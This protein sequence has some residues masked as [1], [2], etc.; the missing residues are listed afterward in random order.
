[1]SIHPCQNHYSWISQQ[2]F[3]I[4]AWKLNHLLIVIVTS[5]RLN[6]A[7]WIASEA[8]QY[9]FQWL[10]VECA[11]A[12]AA[13]S[14]VTENMIVLT[15]LLL[16]DRHHHHHVSS[17]CSYHNNDGHAICKV[18][19]ERSNIMS[20]WGYHFDEIGDAHEKWIFFST[21]SN[22]GIGGEIMP[23]TLTCTNHLFMYGR[24]G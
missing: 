18:V 9:W 14:A 23:Q 21:T 2:L 15:Y 10:I 7:L 20:K 22:V 12:T 8:E 11:A 19:R 4:I 13:A 5:C 1:M 3:N 6:I 16:D 24:V 17:T